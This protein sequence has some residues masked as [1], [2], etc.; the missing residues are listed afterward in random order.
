MRHFMLVAMVVLAVGCKSERTQACKEAGQAVAKRASADLQ[1]V[2]ADR[3][4][5]HCRLD[6]WSAAAIDC[7]KTSTNPSAECSDKLTEAQLKSLQD[8]SPMLKELP[9][10]P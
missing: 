5:Q 10:T 4:E 9:L 1:K 7:A 3:I 8:D 6:R 2:V